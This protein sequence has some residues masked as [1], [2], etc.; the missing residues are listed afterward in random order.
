MAV[1]L[2][3]GCSSG[4]GKLAALAFARQGHTVFA[5]MRNLDK[6]PALRDEAR[7]A[8]LSIEIIQMDVND[9]ASVEKPSLQCLHARAASTCW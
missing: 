9:T 3:T 6:A 2:I 8:G 7:A 4:F 5:S 1:V